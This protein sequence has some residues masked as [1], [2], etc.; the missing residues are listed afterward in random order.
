[1]KGNATALKEVW[2]RLHGKVLQTEKLQLGG[3]DGRQVTIEVVYADQSKES[4]TTKRPGNSD[5]QG[6]IESCL[7]QTRMSCS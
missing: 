5:A 3:T 1:M 7:C 4:T 6:E 2:E